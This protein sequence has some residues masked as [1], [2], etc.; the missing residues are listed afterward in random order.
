MSQFG[1]PYSSTLLQPLRD[2]YADEA[3][4]VER[5]GLLHN[6]KTNLD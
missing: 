3:N 5:M 1:F 4:I 2:E 6:G